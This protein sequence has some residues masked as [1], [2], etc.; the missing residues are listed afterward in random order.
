MSNDVILRQLIRSA[1]SIGANL[2]EA[3]G[4][5]SRNDFI[6]VMNIAKKESRESNYWLRLLM[7]TNPSIPQIEKLISESEELT[8]I[9]KASVKKSKTNF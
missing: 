2:E 1:T 9:L 4:A 6:Y 3:A 8:K 5:H 7:Q